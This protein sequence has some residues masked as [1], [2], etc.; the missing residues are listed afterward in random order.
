MNSIYIHHNYPDITQMSARTVIIL[1]YMGITQKRGLKEIYFEDW[2]AFLKEVR[3][4][5]N[6]HAGVINELKT[7]AKEYEL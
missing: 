3:R 7:F 1:H 2:N 4:Q 6:A 5:P